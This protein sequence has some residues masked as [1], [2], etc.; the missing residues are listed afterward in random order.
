MFKK[1][2][3]SKIGERNVKCDEVVLFGHH[4]NEPKYKIVRNFYK[5]LAQNK[6]KSYYEDVTFSTLS[7]DK[8]PDPKKFNAKRS[9]HENISSI[10]VAQ[11]FHKIPIDIHENATHIVLFNGRG[12]IR[13]LTNIISPY[14]D[15]DPRKFAKIIDGYLRQKEFIVIDLNKPRSE[16]FSL[17][18]VTPL[19]LEKEIEALKD[20]KSRFQPK[21]VKDKAL[22][23]ALFVDRLWYH[24]SAPILWRCIEFS[25]EG[26]RQN[27]CGKNKSGPLYW[28]LMKFKRVIYGKTNSLYCSKMVYLKLVGLKISDALLSAI[29]RSCPNINFLILDQS[30]SF[31]NIPIIEIAKYCLKLLHLSLDACKAITDRCINEIV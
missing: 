22:Y 18:W 19:N 30:Y 15:A 7:P 23:P 17:Q 1:R 28:R 8:I 21:A 2:K 5:Y 25:I 14:T 27:Q 4:L 6:S 10:Y 12:S 13:K 16:S 3:C 9:R 20:N 29:L 31:S 24:C 11:K 26:Y